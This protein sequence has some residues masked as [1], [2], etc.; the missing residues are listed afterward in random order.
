MNTEKQASLGLYEVKLKMAAK[1]VE[2][3]LKAYRNHVT[4]M[5]KK[6]DRLG[7]KA[8]M[9]FKVAKAAKTL[10]DGVRLDAASVKLKAEVYELAS[11]LRAAE[12]YLYDM[13]GS[14]RQ[15]GLKVDDRTL[16]EE[17]RFRGRTLED[18]LAV[19]E[20]LLQWKGGGRLCVEAIGMNRWF[21][22]AFG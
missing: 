13:Q 9:L 21:V 22:N 14:T 6:V 7:K 5:R 12:R 1:E 2:T 16:L 10:G 19:V 8:E 4:K 20:W 15:V 17:R 3:A 11:N 18:G